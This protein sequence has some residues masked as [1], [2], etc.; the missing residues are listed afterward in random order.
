LL[1]QGVEIVGR[2][3]RAGP[4]VTLVKEGQR[5]GVGAQVYSC[6]ECKQ[7]RE[8]NETYC[9]VN[10]I[11]TYGSR[12]PETGIVSQGG[13]A[14]HIR[15]HEY[16]VFPIPNQ[17]AMWPNLTSPLLWDVFAVGTYFT[18]SL[19]FWYVGLVPDLASV[20]DRTSR[21]LVLIDGGRELHEGGIRVQLLDDG[22]LR[23]IK[24]NGE[25]FDS[26]AEGFTQ[27]LSNWSEVP[28]ANDG[29]GV[30]IDNRTAVTR[31]CGERMDYG[32]GI[33]VLMQQ[34]KRRKD[35]SAEMSQCCLVRK[36]VCQRP[37][38]TSGVTHLL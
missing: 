13:L 2:V 19:L 21:L 17:M 11:N 23:F 7:C 31:W 15:A 38:Q 37:K 22:A 6:G 16:W 8:D 32:L 5:V 24:P 14:S 28:K 4:K 1:T 30:Q 35:I 36:N 20:R 3:V 10:L 12:W 34:A 29:R 26:V 27:P 33:Q 25:T 18:V 9:Q